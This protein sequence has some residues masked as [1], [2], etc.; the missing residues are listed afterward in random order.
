MDKVHVLLQS[1]T[2]ELIGARVALDAEWTYIMTSGSRYDARRFLD[3]AQLLATAQSDIDKA[4]KL[5][6]GM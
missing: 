6:E 4:R 5:L 1:V 2:G 3:A